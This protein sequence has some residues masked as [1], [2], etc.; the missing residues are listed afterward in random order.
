MTVPEHEDP[1]PPSVPDVIAGVSAAA[2]SVTGAYYWGFFSDLGS[3]LL[4]TLSIQDFLTGG[5]IAVVPMGVAFGLGGIA[6]G[7]SD[8]A[9]EVARGGT[10]PIRTGWQEL[11]PPEWF[12]P[13]FWFSLLPIHLVKTGKA[14]LAVTILLLGLFAAINLVLLG[15]GIHPALDVLAIGLVFGLSLGWTS[16]VASL[17]LDRVAVML[18][19]AMSLGATSF[20]LGR[21][22]YFGEVASARRGPEDAIVL[23]EGGYFEGRVILSTSNGLFLTGT[24]GITQY[25]PIATVKFVRH[26]ALS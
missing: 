16:V 2:V 26:N 8:K 3:S 18:V 24:S 21:A 10:K 11:A 25:F 23:N 13:P 20:V 15:M 7:M 12:F 19:I 22:F 1:K 6:R 9:D 4:S 5:I 14:S 17:G